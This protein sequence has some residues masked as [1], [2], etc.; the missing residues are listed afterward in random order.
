MLKVLGK[1]ILNN[2]NITQIS[3]QYSKRMFPFAP[4]QSSWVWN[5][6]HSLDSKLNMS[7]VMIVV[8][9]GISAKKQESLMF[10]ILSLPNFKLS[11]MKNIEPFDFKS[12]DERRWK[13]VEELLEENNLILN[14]S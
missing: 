6:S 11:I 1:Q 9:K 4:N 2:R 3:D 10:S 12:R 8:L 14:M 13:L 7:L 5:K